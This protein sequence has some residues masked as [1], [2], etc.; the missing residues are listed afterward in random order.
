MLLLSKENQKALKDGTVNITDL[1]TELMKTN[2]AWELA[3]SLAE[4]MATA[5][6]FTPTKITVSQEDYNQIMSIFR[7]RGVKDDGSAETR[8]RKPLKKEGQ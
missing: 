1:A 4:L 5:E 6:S 7:V 3:V 8:G 2:S